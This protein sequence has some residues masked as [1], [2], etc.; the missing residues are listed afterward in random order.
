[1]DRKGRLP[2]CRERVSPRIA[3][4]GGSEDRREE[5]LKHSWRHALRQ[6]KKIRLAPDIAD[7]L[8]GPRDDHFPGPA[9]S[10]KQ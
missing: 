3:K 10:W 2:Q 1:M 5:S 7:D 9:K 4:G 8:F 6:K